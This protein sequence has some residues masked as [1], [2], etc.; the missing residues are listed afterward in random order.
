VVAGADSVEQVRANV[1][2][3]D[4][5]VPAGLMAEVRDWAAGGR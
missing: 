4:A 2:L 5:Q 1:A 3:M